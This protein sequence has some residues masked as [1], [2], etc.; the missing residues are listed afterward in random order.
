M[1]EQNVFCNQL[2]VGTQSLGNFNRWIDEFTLWG[3]NVKMFRCLQ[4]LS[5][6]GLRVG[7]LQLHLFP[8]CCGWNLYRLRK[9]DIASLWLR[10]WR[11][12][13]TFLFPLIFMFSPKHHWQQQT[14]IAGESTAM[15]RGTV[16]DSAKP[17]STRMRFHTHSVYYLSILYSFRK[18]IWGLK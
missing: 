7:F 16:I 9:N 11:T 17:F 5:L 3:W 10:R 12:D 6:I 18:L 8:S 13:S 15:L 2:V 4:W 14:I 1:D